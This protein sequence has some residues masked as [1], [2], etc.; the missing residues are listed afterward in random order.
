MAITHRKSTKYLTILSAFGF[1]LSFGIFPEL[2]AAIILFF[3]IISIAQNKIFRAFMIELLLFLWTLVRLVFYIRSNG[4]WFIGILEGVYFWI[5]WQTAFYIRY[6]WDDYY[7]SNVIKPLRIGLLVGVVAVTLLTLFNIFVNRKQE[8]ALKNASQAL[9]SKNYLHFN[10]KSE[11]DSYVLKNFGSFAPGRYRLTLVAQTEKNHVVILSLFQVGSA[12]FD[13]KC[14]LFPTTTTC[15][16]EGVFKQSGTINGLFG[17]FLNSEW[18]LGDP[19]IKVAAFNLIQLSGSKFSIDLLFKERQSTLA[20][21][22]NAFGVWMST[23][24]FIFLHT[25][26]NL[27]SALGFCLSLFLV[28][29]SGSRNAFLSLFISIFI[30]VFQYK[31]KYLL[32]LSLLVLILFLILYCF[33]LR[34]FNVLSLID[35]ED[36]VQAFTKSISVWLESPIFGATNFPERLMTLDNSGFSTSHAHNLIL[37]ILGESGL[38]GLLV[39]WGL[40]L[41]VLF[42]S[43]RN[44]IIN[45]SACVFIFFVNVSDYLFYYAPIQ[46]AFW[47]LVSGFF[48]TGR[49]KE[50]NTYDSKHK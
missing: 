24:S 21:N 40:V 34:S 44:Q 2:N 41:S 14:R 25:R 27:F 47:M 36:R 3:G 5:M 43:T 38:V 1:G 50:E 26:F 13:N 9:T 11:T 31:R 30:F 10:A 8:L 37:Q 12:R 6:T 32:T 49:P 19:S 33:Q 23:V 28:V 16:I 22:E 7:I 35:F 15:E 42:K 46:I 4:Q 17:S 29:T 45:A 18:K 39:F 48:A 20:F